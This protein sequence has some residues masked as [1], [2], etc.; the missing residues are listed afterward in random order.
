MTPHMGLYDDYNDIYK[1]KSLKF[2]YSRKKSFKNKLLP[3]IYRSFNNKWQEEYTFWVH[4][5]IIKK[6]CGTF[7]WQYFEGFLIVFYLYNSS[8]FEQNVLDVPKKCLKE[9]KYYQK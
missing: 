5:T 8:I 4:K 3:T 9:L 1:K 6:M 7:F 2:A